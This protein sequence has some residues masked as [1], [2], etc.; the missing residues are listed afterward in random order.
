MPGGRLK[1]LLKQ[2]AA[3]HLPA[4]ILNRRKMGF[5][6]PIGRWFAGELKPMLARHLLD[7]PELTDL[8]FSRPAL[9]RLIEDHAAGRADH[10]HR[11]FALLTLA[12]YLRWL[13]RPEPPTP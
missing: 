6:V 3:E 5:A 7:G 11:L 2:L 8:G 13:E 4:E 1:H 9:E 12:V 10:T